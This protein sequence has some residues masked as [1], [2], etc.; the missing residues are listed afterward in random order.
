MADGDLDHLVYATPDLDATVADLEEKL[1]VRPATGGRH[2]G[3]GTRN[4]LLRLS[5]FS[6]LEILAPDPAQ[7]VAKPLW[8]GLDTLP[9]PRLL[10]WAIQLGDVERV[11]GDAARAGV[12]LGTISHGSRQTTDGETLRWRLT[13]P[14][15]MIDDGIV[16]FLIDWGVS[17]HPATTAPR[18]VTMR[19]MRGEH[20][21]AERVSRH[22]AAVSGRLEVVRAPKPALVATL[23]GK[24][25]EIE[26]R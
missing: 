2:M 16:P 22:V 1:G 23:V 25:G 7:N 26:L 10:T 3:R 15:A 18:G 11:M 19:A 17:R 5:D 21:D 13:N 24:R 4:A 14:D 6:Y 9:A 12:M 20:P 8:F